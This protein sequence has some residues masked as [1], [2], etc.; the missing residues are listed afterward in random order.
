[1]PPPCSTILIDVAV[2]ILLG[3]LL[4]FEREWAEKPAGL[5]THMLI[6]GGSSLLVG[7]IPALLQY[8]AATTPPGVLRSDPIRMVQAIITGISFLG[9]GTIIQRSKAG[10]VKGLTTAA[11]VF[12]A[13]VIGVTVGIRQFCLAVAVTGLALLALRGLAI[14]E[15]KLVI[16]HRK[17]ANK[18]PVQNSKTGKASKKA[19]Q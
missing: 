15:D 9:A 14:I 5:R 8:A 10:E 16:C 4:G 6:A 17:R 11:S 2:A 18:P 12:F 3:G 13:A 19:E 1:M 7:L